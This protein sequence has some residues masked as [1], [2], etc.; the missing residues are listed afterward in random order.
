MNH[1]VPF[2]PVRSDL[3]TP[4]E[5]MGTLDPGDYRSFQRT[6][7]FKC[8]AYYKRHG[9][10]A[11]ND[12]LTSIFE[13]LHDNSITQATLALLKNRPRVAAI[14]GGHD[15]A[16]GTDVY[17][18]VAQIAAALSNEKFLIASGGGPGAM[19]AAH[20]GAR[21]AD[22]ADGLKSAIDQLKAADASLPAHASDVIGKDGCVSEEIVEALH[23]WVM[24]A[25][26][27]SQAAAGES[28]ALPTWYYGHEPSTPFATHIAKYFQNSIREDGLI[29]LAAHGIV[30]AS[31]KAG[32]LQEIFQDSVRNYY[33]DASVPFSPMVFLGKSYWEETLPAAS[34]LKALFANAKR[35]QEFTDNV[36][37]TDEANKAMDFIVRKAPGDHAHLERLRSL[38]MIA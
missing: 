15:E 38:G 25:W 16:R 10:A 9:S 1:A 4:Q 12:A 17:R 30:F 21:F 20:L 18:A 11:P 36:L 13:A 28:L 2:S 14:M 35:E 5:L 27:L 34:L 19:E 8:F 6:L 7:D 33:R 23:K 29:T 26:G 32:T 37:I 24:P 31:G 3:Y 22:N